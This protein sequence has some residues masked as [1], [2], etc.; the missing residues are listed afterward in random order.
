[1]ASQ[2]GTTRQYTSVTEG[3]TKPVVACP[4]CK[5]RT[6]PRGITSTRYQSVAGGEKT[7]ANCG[8]DLTRTWSK[9]T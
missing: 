6:A 1:M 3:G 7:C 9:T 4:L 5:V 8:K 2:Y